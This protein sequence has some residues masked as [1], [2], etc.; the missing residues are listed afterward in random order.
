[1]CLG[2]I[3]LA[4]ATVSQAYPVPNPV[5]TRWE[6]DFEPHYLRIATLQDPQ[7]GEPRAYWYLT[8]TITNNSDS[9]LRYAPSFVMYDSEGNL[10]DSGAPAHVT[11]TILDLLDNPLIQD[12][13]TIGGVLR[14]GRANAKSGVAIWPV[15][16]AGVDEVTIF[17]GNISGETATVEDPATGDDV[18]LRKTLALTYDTPGEVLALMRRGGLEEP[19]EERWIMR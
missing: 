15:E 8:Y 18:V 10:Q 4:S 2:L 6:L 9:D 13:L 19:A 1:V 3:T 11:R 5:P 14:V 17:V 16:S 7:T 12:E